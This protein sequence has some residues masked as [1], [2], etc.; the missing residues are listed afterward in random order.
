MSIDKNSTGVP[1]INV[2]KRTT[3]VNLWMVV[4]VLGFFA[5]MAAVAVW[6]SREK[7][8]APVSGAVGQRPISSLRA[9]V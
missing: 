6:A 7:N 9:A 2:H 1:E 4:A 5:V 8:H 3:K